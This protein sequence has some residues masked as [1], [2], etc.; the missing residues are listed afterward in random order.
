MRR[1]VAIFA[2]SSCAACSRSR[3][4]S[5]ESRPEH[6]R[7]GHARDRGAERKPQPLDR[8]GQRGADRLQVRRAFQRHAGAAQRHHHAEQ[9]AEHAEQ[10][11]Q[12]DQVRRQRRPGKATRSPSMRRR[13][14]LRRPG[15]RPVEPVAQA[16][17]RGGQIR[18]RARQ[19]GG[20]LPIAMQFQRTRQVAR[21]DQQ[22][23]GQRQRV[24]ADVAGA[25][26][27]H[28]DQADQEHGEIKKISEHDVPVSGCEGLRASPSTG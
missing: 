9:R 25:D 24:R 1:V 15:C 4:H 12:A 7:A 5:A 26:P 17:R 27:A 20:G 6:R 10:H 14:A 19:R 18:H 2:S 28:S 16:G 13:T 3:R 22:R 21:A 11:Q 8:R 23:D